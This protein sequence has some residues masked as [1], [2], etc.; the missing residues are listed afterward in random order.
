M[1]SVNR[2]THEIDATG[3]AAGRLAA[4]I[5]MKLSGKNKPTYTP[6]IDEGDHVNVINASKMKFTGR[7]LVQK[8]YYHH[9]MHP[10][11]LKRTPM[12]RVFEQDPGD[13]V[14]RAVYGMLPKNKCR[15]EV[16]K[17]LTVKA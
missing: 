16:M 12:K 11:G 14:K 4:N 8:D 1:K 7:K 10:G 5:A 2:K 6:H 17:R 13:V 9:T 3:Q 15:D